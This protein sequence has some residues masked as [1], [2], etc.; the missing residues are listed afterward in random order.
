VVYVHPAQEEH[1]AEIET[2]ARHPGIAPS[3]GDE[4]TS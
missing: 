4:A 1:M 3:A 2:R